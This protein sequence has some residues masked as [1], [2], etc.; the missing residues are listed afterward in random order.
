MFSR[1]HPLLAVL[2]VLALPAFSSAWASPRLEGM[3]EQC[4]DNRGSC[5]ENCSI[6]FGSHADRRPS[7]GR[8]LETCER[9]LTDC[10]DQ[11][12]H[13]ARESLEKRRQVERSKPDYSIPQTPL[14]S[15]VRDSQRSAARAFD[16]NAPDGETETSEPSTATQPVVAP[17]ASA[18]ASPE[19]AGPASPPTDAAKRSTAATVDADTDDASAGAPAPKSPRES[20]GKKKRAAVITKAP[21]AKPAKAA[22][23]ATARKPAKASAKAPTPDV[24][25]D[26]HEQKKTDLS[27]WDPAAP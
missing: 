4:R 5:R 3:L 24:P 14:P 11:A 16:P 25:K 1:A 18:A 7:L 6:E 27:G 12:E 2:V 15:D 10:E 17:P 19:K 21:A 13:A 22:P 20:A 23:A 9:V 8:C 26:D